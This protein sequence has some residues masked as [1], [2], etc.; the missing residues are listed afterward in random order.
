MITVQHFC[1]RCK[2]VIHEGG[3]VLD[4]YA[5]KLRDTVD[6]PID[7]CPTCSDRFAEFLKE[8]S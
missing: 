4:I 3:I 1:D 2:T 8:K 5:G 6:R 7:L